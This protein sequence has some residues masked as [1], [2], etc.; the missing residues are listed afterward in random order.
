[1][2]GPIQPGDPLQNSNKM[3]VVPG[4]IKFYPDPIIPT[5]IPSTQFGMNTHLGPFIRCSNCGYD[6]ITS[7]CF[8]CPRCG[9]KL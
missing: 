9:I 3:K 7:H 4:Y 2:S 8:F 1:M 6:K 5:C